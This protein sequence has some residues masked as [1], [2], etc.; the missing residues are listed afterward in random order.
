MATPTQQAEVVAVRALSPTVRELTLAPLEHVVSYQ[1]GQWVSLRLPVGIR[2]PLA[3]AYSLAE[4]PRADGRLVLAFDR[5]PNGLGSTFLFELNRGDRIGI[6]DAMGRFTAPDGVRELMMVARYSGIVPLRCILRHLLSRPRP[7]AIR[8][9]LSS[10]AA[11]EL[12]YDDEFRRLD[13]THESFRYFPVIRTGNDLE[14]DKA[15]ARKAIG[16]DGFRPTFVPMI[17]GVRAFVEPM[18]A[19][20]LELGLDRKAIR[21]ETYD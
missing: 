19:C 12:I 2:P 4:P 8:L 16:P 1:P 7:P 14:L 17:C 5:V 15:A 18:R 9:V 21:Y 13:A 3:R 11:E 6:T 10:P 20:F